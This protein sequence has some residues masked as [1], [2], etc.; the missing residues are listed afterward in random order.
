[1]KR[2]WKNIILIGF[3]MTLCVMAT[4]CMGGQKDIKKDEAAAYNEVIA[5]ACEEFGY[6]YDEQVVLPKGS[7]LCYVLSN[8]GETLDIRVTI[9]EESAYNYVGCEFE[10]ERAIAAVEDNTA[11]L[12]Q[13]LPVLVKIAEHFTDEISVA[14]VANYLNDDALWKEGKNEDEP[15]MYKDYEGNLQHIIEEDGEEFEEYFFFGWDNG[16]KYKLR[17]DK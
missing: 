12:D 17:K 14:D 6:E 2:I 3:A 7:A 13:H 10:M 8:G 15:F 1:M 9:N 16:E 4:G 11:G 5:A